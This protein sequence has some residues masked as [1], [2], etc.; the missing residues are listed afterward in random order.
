MQRRMERCPSR[1][2]E[3]VRMRIADP[4]QR[5]EHAKE[6]L[7]QLDSVTEDPVGVAVQ[8]A[9]IVLPL[10][11]HGLHGDSIHFT[12]DRRLGEAVRQDA[13]AVTYCRQV[14]GQTCQNNLL[15]NVENEGVVA[16]H[17]GEER[18]E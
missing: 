15:G 8:G 2:D 7:H 14:V 11:L 10:L 3:L 12:D 16:R 1:R 17:R 9:Q 4:P 6:H 18:I 5:L 13:L